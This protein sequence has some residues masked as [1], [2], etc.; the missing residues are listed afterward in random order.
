MRIQ[1]INPTYYSKPQTAQKTPSFYGSRTF[2]S[3]LKKVLPEIKQLVKSKTP[4]SL[5]TAQ[6][7]AEKIYP[8]IKVNAITKIEKSPYHANNT[9]GYYNRLVSFDVLANTAIVNEESINI[10]IPDCKKEFLNLR[11]YGNFL[12]ELIHLIQ[13]HSD[14]RISSVD[15]METFFKK[16]NSSSIKYATT[17]ASP[18]AFVEMQN[19]LLHVIGDHFK[20][21]ASGLPK[22][23]PC[24]E[25]K[26]LDKFF[27]SEYG[28]PLPQY[29]KTLTCK[30]VKHLKSQEG[31]INI[32]NKE[33]MN[34]CAYHANLE[35]EAYTIG[36]NFL[37]K[38][39]GYKTP[40]DLDYIPIMFG[41]LEKTLKKM[42]S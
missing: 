4:F 39:L 34:Y 31:N 41:I 25:E 35:K 42:I 26:E 18:Q 22:P 3:Q 17:I 8:E 9:I 33:L 6:K 12:H 20:M 11:T 2:D 29:I 32:N 40:C 23:L 19:N 27:M 16:Y 30:I 21:D 36:G 37:K 38:Q 1:N 28:M 7:I 15:F 5:D 24:V 14:D 13:E 10:T